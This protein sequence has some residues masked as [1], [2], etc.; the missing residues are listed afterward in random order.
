MVKT[1]YDFF[2]QKGKTTMSLDVTIPAR[3]FNTQMIKI[4]TDNELALLPS[5]NELI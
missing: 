1:Y 3:F 2:K 5:Y 4:Q